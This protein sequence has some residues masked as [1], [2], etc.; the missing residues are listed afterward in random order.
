MRILLLMFVVDTRMLTA[1]ERLGVP[2]TSDQLRSIRHRVR[3]SFRGLMETEKDVKMRRVIK[4]G[5]PF[6]EIMRLARTEKVDLKDERGD[7]YG[8]AK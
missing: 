3:L 8:D 4:E 2:V 6:T 7:D 5:A 1:V